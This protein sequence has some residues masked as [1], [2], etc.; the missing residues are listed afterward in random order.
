ML[1]GETASEPSDYDTPPRSIPNESEARPG[2]GLDVAPL[3][4]NLNQRVYIIIDDKNK[5]MSTRVKTLSCG[6]ELWRSAGE[7]DM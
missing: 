2:R 3:N 6:T 5:P 4:I 7:L 1:Q